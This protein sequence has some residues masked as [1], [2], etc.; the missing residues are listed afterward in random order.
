M[1]DDRLLTDDEPLR[2]SDTDL[3]PPHGDAL[4]EEVTFGRTDRYA[5]LDDQDATREER[6]D[7]TEGGSGKPGRG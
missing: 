2:D 5:N 4:R 6:Q 1:T 3:T 7:E